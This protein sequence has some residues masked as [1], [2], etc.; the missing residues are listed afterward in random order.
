V[1]KVIVNKGNCLEVMAKLEDKS[2]DLILTDLPYG[3]TECGWDTEIDLDALWKQFTRIITDNGTIILFGVDP[4]SSKLVMK[5][6]GLFKYRW[7]WKHNRMANFAQAPY[8]PLKNTEDILVFSK[9]TI[10][11]NSKNKMRYYPQ[12][13]EEVDI[14]LKGKTA[15]SLRPGRKTQQDYRQKGTGYPTQLIEFAKDKDPLHPTQKPVPLLEYLIKTYTLEGD[16]VLDSCMGSGTTG[17][18]CVNTNRNFYGIEIDKDFFETAKDNIK[19]AI[20]KRKETE[21]V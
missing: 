7:I 11:K 3:K 14:L 19:N 9:A 15:N 16:L 8:M 10:A 5:F 13:V 20:V 2:V 6:A 4:F 18:A 21:N 17:V 12:G 1:S